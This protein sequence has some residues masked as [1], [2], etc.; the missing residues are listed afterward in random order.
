MTI[1]ENLIKLLDDNINY[2]AIHNDNLPG[3]LAD[4]IIQLFPPNVI[5]E[6]LETLLKSRIT[7]G[8]RSEVVLHGLGDEITKI[9]GNGSN[10]KER[11]YRKALE[12][13]LADKYENDKYGKS[14]KS[15]GAHHPIAKKIFHYRK[16]P[17]GQLERI[18]AL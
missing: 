3:I 13:E 18:L 11:L 15:C 4:E 6:K 12:R 8:Y 5:K 1:K 2:D 7:S 17:T 9:L 16:C 10:I 14:C